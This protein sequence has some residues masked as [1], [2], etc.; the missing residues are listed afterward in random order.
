MTLLISNGLKTPMLAAFPTV[1]N[2]GAILVYS[3]TQPDSAQYPPTGTLLAIV[4]NNGAAWALGSPNNGLRFINTGSGYVLP[5]PTQDWKCVGVA[6][7]I[8]GWA[9]LV[10]YQDTLQA[11]SILP[12]VAGAVNPPT[13]TEFTLRNIAITTGQAQSVDYWLYGIPPF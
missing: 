7:G 4:S 8:A 6:D 3:G 11:S 12:R 2:G 5:D 13:H 1:F 10:S 9:R